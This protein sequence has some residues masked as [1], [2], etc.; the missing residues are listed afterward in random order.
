MV[1][2]GA[3]KAMKTLASNDLF[4]DFPYHP[5]LL[6]A[7]TSGKIA[8]LIKRRADNRTIDFRF[9][10]SMVLAM[11]RQPSY[12]SSTRKA[13]S[14]DASRRRGGRKGALRRGAGPDPN[15]PAE[16]EPYRAPAYARYATLRCT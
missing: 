5:K 7:R 11:P 8:P 16:V 3:A 9:R 1:A 12:F 14:S 4:T 2:V 10:P 6:P 15:H 13:G